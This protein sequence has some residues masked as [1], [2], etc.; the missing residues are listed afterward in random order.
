MNGTSGY[1]KNILIKHL[2]NHKVL[3]FA[4]A[5]RVRK[6]FG[7]FEKRTPGCGNC[8]FEQDTRYSASLHCTFFLPS[9]KLFSNNFARLGK[10]ALSG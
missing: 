6:L 3:D 2:C 7:A 9:I 5:F 8:V 1:I 4:S 10:L